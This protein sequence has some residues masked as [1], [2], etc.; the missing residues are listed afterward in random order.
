MPRFITGSKIPYRGR[1]MSLTV[2]RTD[3]ERATVT[4]RN[5][6]TVELPHWVGDDADHLVASELKHWLKQR[7]RRDVQEEASALDCSGEAQQPG[8]VLGRFSRV[9]PLRAVSGARND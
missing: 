4:Y 8:P 5:G 1:N 6:F 2:C 9:L 7:A 3:A